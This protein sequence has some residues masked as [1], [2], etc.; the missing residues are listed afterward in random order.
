MDPLSK[1]SLFEQFLTERRCLKNVTPSTIEWY[2]TAFKA[3]QRSADSSPPPTLIYDEGMTRPRRN[4]DVPIAF[5]AKVL[6]LPRTVSQLVRLLLRD[7]LQS[8]RVSNY[9]S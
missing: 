8:A 5:L 1:S 7:V 4:T 6:R 9:V 3:F 2:E